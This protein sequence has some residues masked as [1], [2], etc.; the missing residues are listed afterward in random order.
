MD[1]PSLALPSL[2]HT[3]SIASEI[4]EAFNS[5]I[6]GS[7][8][9]S[10]RL[11]EDPFRGYTV[12]QAAFHRNHTDTPQV[13]NDPTKAWIQPRLASKEQWL[14]KDPLGLCALSHVLFRRAQRTRSIL[15]YVLDVCDDSLDWLFREEGA[16]TF[17]P[18]AHNTA[19]P[20]TNAQA[21]LCA[22]APDTVEDRSVSADHAFQPA[23]IDSDGNPYGFAI[24]KAA[25]LANEGQIFS[26]YAEECFTD[27]RLNLKDEFDLPLVDYVVTAGRSDLLAQARDRTLLY[28]T[29]E[30]ESKMAVELAASHGLLSEDKQDGHVSFSGELLHIELYESQLAFIQDPLIRTICLTAAKPAAQRRKARFQEIFNNPL[31]TTA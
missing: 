4:F 17:I 1:Q 13:Q 23:G 3:T 2:F 18:S 19:R 5:G 28:R 12:L 16:K 27:K 25:Y 11:K 24:H 31:T 15:S 29:R 20:M 30:E 10:H 21:V 7:E 14:E 9:L 8:L 6:T 26:S 22:Y